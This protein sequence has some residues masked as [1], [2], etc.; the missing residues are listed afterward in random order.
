MGRNV[1][2]IIVALVLA[3]VGTVVLVGYVGTAEERARAGEELVEVYVV[4]S[5]IATGT[6]GS[7]IEGLVRIEEVPAKVR[8][9]GHV[10]NL[11]AIGDLVAAVDLLP[12]EQLLADRFVA[13]TDVVNRPV[14]VIV[15]DDAIELT[16]SLE[17]QRIIGG[18]LEP[19]DTVAVFASF[20]PFDLYPVGDGETLIEID[21]Q[22]LPVSTEDLPSQTPNTTDLLLRKVLV[23]AVQFDTSSYGNDRDRDAL[24]EAPGNNLLVTLALT[25]ADAERLVFTAE[26]GLIW[27][28]IER[29]TVPEE[30]TP[31]QTRGSVYLEPSSSGAGNPLA[32][33]AVGS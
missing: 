33:T 19:G 22:E 16:V 28:G 29:S 7:D 8:A 5:R 18:L 14:G 31:I 17:P 25:P 13:R 21:G 30:Q 15:P 32:S 3:A 12:G 27:L 24:T 10:S 4:D 11:A 6:A 2:G 20:E 9:D 1:I 23:T 26:F